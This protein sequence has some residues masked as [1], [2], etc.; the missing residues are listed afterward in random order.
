MTVIFT[1]LL[2]VFLLGLAGRCLY[3]W[4]KQLGRVDPKNR[5]VFITVFLDMMA[6][7]LAWFA[8][9]EQDESRLGLPAWVR[10]IG[11]AVTLGGVVLAIGA[12]AQLRALENTTVLVTTGFFAKLRHPMYLAFMGWF[13]AWPVYRDAAISVCMGALGIMA[14][15][16]WRKNEERALSL[17]FGQA[18]REYQRRTWF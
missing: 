3:E 6:M 8:L 17:Q 16:Y 4:L 11:L 5:A 9:S 14:V 15:A 7:W 10:W 13:V 18:Y 2:V 12:L 1:L